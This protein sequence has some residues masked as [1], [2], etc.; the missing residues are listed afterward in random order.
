MFEG[1]HFYTESNRKEL[2]EFIEV[3][4]SEILQRSPPAILLGIQTPHKEFDKCVH[5]LFEEQVQKTPTMDAV[6]GKSQWCTLY[7]IYWH[8]PP[9]VQTVHTS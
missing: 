1:G 6:I 2:L 7:T 3:Y 5:T 4:V 9:T 8:V